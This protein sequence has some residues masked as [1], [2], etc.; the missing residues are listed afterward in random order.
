MYSNACDP[1][2]SM[3]EESAVV[4]M[5]SGWHKSLEDAVLNM[6]TITII[7]QLSLLYDGLTC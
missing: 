7:I 2:E 5:P 4:R 1:M 6:S 3:S